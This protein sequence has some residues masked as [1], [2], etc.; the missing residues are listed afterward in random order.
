MSA[1]NTYVSNKHNMSRS[2]CFKQDAKT[3]I[4]YIF[5]F[6]HISQISILNLEMGL[7]HILY[8][9]LAAVYILAQICQKKQQLF[10]IQLTTQAQ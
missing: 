7:F 2:N 4:T 5:P 10:S 6:I 3:E 8:F 1:Q 9:S